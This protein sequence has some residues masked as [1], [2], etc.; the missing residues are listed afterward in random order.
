MS[1]KFEALDV[2][3]VNNEEYSTSNMVYSLFQ[4]IELF[5]GGEI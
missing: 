3:I 4:A 5:D 2:K 1:E